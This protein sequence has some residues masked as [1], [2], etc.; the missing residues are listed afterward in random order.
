M[1]LYV[2][3]VSLETDYFS[4]NVGLPAYAIIPGALVIFSIWAI[5]RSETIKELPKK[6]LIF[7][8]ASFICWFIAEQSWNLYEH[9]LDIDPYPSVAD[10]FYISA[11]IFMFIALWIFLKSTKKK[12]SKK[13]ITFASIISLLILVPSLI[14]I[15]EEGL[16]DEFLENFV[17]L[18][19]PISDSILLIPAIITFLFLISSK[20]NFF[21]LMI[22]S[23]IIIFLVADTV[24]L[25]LV[26]HDMY[27]DGHPVDLLWISSYTIW[28]TMMFYIIYESK[29]YRE[30]K[31]PEVY[32]KY[33]SKKIEKYGVHL[34]LIFINITVI[35]FLW[36]S[37]QVIGIEQGE[38]STFFFWFLI[39]MVV[40]FSSIV[41]LLNSRLN[42]T[43][44]NRTAQLE[45]TS[46][47]LIKAERFSAI[48]EVASRI[49]HDIRNPLSNVKMSI[50]LMKNSP[51]DTK[52]ADKAINEKLE[53]ASKNIERISHQVNDVLE[54]VKN[55]ELKRENVRVSNILHDTVE[56]MQIPS[57]IRIKMPKSDI[58]VFVD[59]FQLQIVFNN[60]ILNAIQAIG[61][62][63]GEILIK[64]SE[65]NDKIIIRF[66]DSGPNIPENIINHIFDTLVT[67][68]QVGTG[69]GLVSCKTIIENHK[70]E[71]TV[72]N[73][74]VTFTIILPDHKI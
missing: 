31:E 62:D 63:N 56:S 48:G 6:S 18:S 38:A 55:R 22:I 10:F 66:E 50:E 49:S 40:I 20:R 12:I 39:M 32:E 45:R 52:I 4:D 58:S 68:K 17:A 41:V 15:F 54:F 28:A 26:I 30:D 8:S 7:L 11:P 42:K 19:Y 27:E 13:K 44:L 73:D 2:A 9:V 64:I 71:I 74:P 61:K 24:F 25:F 36:G 72:Q 3:N 21:W 69:L 51:P 67:T 60:I 5:T 43:L 1:S 35:L 33:G 53:V 47:E 70:G 37:S 16:E 57:H 34:A 14:S 23:G 65:K 59:L 29:R 46:D